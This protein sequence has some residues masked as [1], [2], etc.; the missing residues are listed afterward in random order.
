MS[1]KNSVLK[2]TL[3]G[4]TLLATSPAWAKGGGGMSEGGKSQLGVNH[5]SL[6]V[7]PGYACAVCADVKAVENGK[8]ASNLLPNDLTVAVDPFATSYIELTFTVRDILA[9]NRNHVL[10]LVYS[11]RTSPS[12]QIPTPRSENKLELDLSALEILAIYSIPSQ[13]MLAQ[14]PTRL[15]AAN[16]SPHSSVSFSVNLDTSILPIFMR[17]SEK[18]YLQAALMTTE[19]FDNGQYDEMILSELDTI[20]FVQNQCPEN[21]ASIAVSEEGNGT[22][23][24]TDI[25]GNTGKT[26]TST[27]TSTASV[28][29]SPGKSGGT[30]IEGTSEPSGGKGSE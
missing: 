13:T 20:G 26:V 19:A 16:P 3:V 8:T 14:R 30:S 17:N 9:Q 12:P 29:V 22:M 6:E 21:N 7:T 5:L 18:A 11:P 4:A 23:T 28:T 10:F 2:K 15:G 24:I 25:Y 27:A 1:N